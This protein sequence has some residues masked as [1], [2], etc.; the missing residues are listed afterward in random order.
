MTKNKLASRN[1]MIE[2]FH[3]V[4]GLSYSKCR[5][6]LKRN[7]WDILTVFDMNTLAD[8]MISVIEPLYDVFKNLSECVTEAINNIDWQ[9][10]KKALEE[11]TLEELEEAQKEDDED[12]RCSI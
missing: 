10:F 1:K 8:V 7:K 9:Q 4:T 3:D 5:E 2:Y 12:D 11:A 6:I